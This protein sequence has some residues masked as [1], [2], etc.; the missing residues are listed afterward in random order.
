MDSAAHVLFC[1]HCLLDMVPPGPSFF[2]R[3]VKRKLNLTFKL[4]FRFRHEIANVLFY[5]FREA[6]TAVCIGHNQGGFSVAT[7]CHECRPN[8]HQL[9]LCWAHLNVYAR[10]HP[11]RNHSQGHLYLALL[12]QVYAL[13]TADTYPPRAADPGATLTYANNAGDVSRRRVEN[14]FNIEKREYDD[15]HTMN[16]ALNERLYE[17][18]GQFLDDV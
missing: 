6:R 9:L 1:N 17:I 16:H 18:L 2:N 14:T 15:K 4:N 10:A 5:C 3:L 12:Q 13:E 7:V 8:L 11:H